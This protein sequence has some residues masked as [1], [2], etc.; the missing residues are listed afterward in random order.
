MDSVNSTTRPPGPAKRM[1]GAYV[2]PSSWRSTSLITSP[3]A[4]TDSSTRRRGHI[5]ENTPAAQNAAPRTRQMSPSENFFMD[6]CFDKARKVYNESH[7]AVAQFRRAAHA[8][9]AR[10]VSAQAAHENFG[11][12]LQSV[13]QDGRVPAP[14]FVLFP[15]PASRSHDDELDA[16]AR[17][18]RILRGRLAEQGARVDDR[19]LAAVEPPPRGVSCA[20]F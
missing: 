12:T 13:N 1:T 17:V 4:G 2:T 11:A 7:A 18:F 5:H 8:A 15:A 14:V 3:K 6:G 16:G 20:V 10:R 19:K 9:P